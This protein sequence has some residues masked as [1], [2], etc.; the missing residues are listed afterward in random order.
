[1]RDQRASCPF[2]ACVLRRANTVTVE[3]RFWVLVGGTPGGARGIR[4]PAAD[5]V[6]A[7]R[8]ERVPGGDRRSAT[9]PSPAR[10]SWPRPRSAAR[11]SPGRART[12]GSAPR[13]AA[14]GPRTAG[15]PPGRADPASSTHRKGVKR[16]GRVGR[17]LL[18][19]PQ[20]SEPLHPAPGNGHTEYPALHHS[21]G[22]L[23][24]QLLLCP[25]DGSITSPP[26]AILRTRRQTPSAHQDGAR[27]CHHHLP[28]PLPQR[29]R[30]SSAPSSSPPPWP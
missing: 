10:R 15:G 5:S 4:R 16:Q 2:P 28:P 29:T 26:G 19:S 3:R 8:G 6:R 23:N 11:P 12:P 21:R 22:E 17:A 30:P 20:M 25:L 14:S 9:R 13:P 1:M 24:R 27:T 18:L 7:G